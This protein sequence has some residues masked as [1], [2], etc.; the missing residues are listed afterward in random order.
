MMGIVDFNR[1]ILTQYLSIMYPLEGV[2]DMGLK[3]GDIVHMHT[4][5]YSQPTIFVFHHVKDEKVAVFH[6]IQSLN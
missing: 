2:F 5:L 1:R 4:D 6:P 3:V